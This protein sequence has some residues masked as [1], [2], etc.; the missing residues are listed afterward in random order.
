MLTDYDLEQVFLTP[1]GTAVEVQLVLVSVVGSP[2]REKFPIV[3]ADLKS[4]ATMLGLRLA[5][6]PDVASVDRARVRVRRGGS[7]E[8]ASGLRAT[9]QEAFRWGRRG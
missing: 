9:L 7:L 4:A 5:E 3:A 1:R 2:F 6:R 8:D